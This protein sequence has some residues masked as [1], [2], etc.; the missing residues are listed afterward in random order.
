MTTELEMLAVSIRAVA[1]RAS[2][3]LVD[4]RTLV[5]STLLAAVAQEHVLVVGP[6]G[7]AKSLAIRQIAEAVGDRYFEY[8]ISKFTEPT[9]IFGAVDLAELRAGRVVVD[10]TDMLPDAQLAFLDEIFLGSSA[11]LNTLLGI[12]NERVYRRG[13]T[14]RYCPLRICVGASNELPTDP[15]LAAFADRFLVRVFVERVADPFLEDLLTAGW[16]ASRPPTPGDADHTGGILDVA[17]AFVDQVDLSL[18]RPALAQAVRLLRRH[19]IELSDRRIVRSQRLVAAAAVLDGRETA[20][21]ADIWPIVRVIPT[22]E[23]QL[24]SEEILHELLADTHN[25]VAVTAAEDASHGPAARAA[26]LADAAREALASELD[27]SRRLRLEG[28][29]REIDASFDPAA[30]P[31]ALVT[32]RAQVVAELQ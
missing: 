19:G 32:I 17:A 25:R 3:G 29:A 22:G 11:I 15:T 1:D 13:H 5:E 24:R 8:L 16:A 9:E 2:R 23:D 21:P 30:L 18:A 26:R 4:R 20:T 28:I 31:A 12:L 7:T 10:T 27:E 6:P 14:I